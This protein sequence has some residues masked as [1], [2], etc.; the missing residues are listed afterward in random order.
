MMD[1]TRTHDAKART[2]EIKAAR[3]IKTDARAGRRPRE[4][5]GMR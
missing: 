5:R 2:L 3:R 1:R 4:I